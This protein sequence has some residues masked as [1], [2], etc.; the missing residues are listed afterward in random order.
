VQQIAFD[1]TGN[2][3]NDLITPDQ[4]VFCLASVRA[5]EHEIAQATGLLSPV[6]AREWKFCKMRRNPKQLL[7]LSKLLEMDWV[8]PA[9]VK[10]FVI[11]KRYMAMTKLVDLI[12][13]PSARSFGVNLYEKGA[14]RGLANLLTLT[15]PVYLGNTRADRFTNLFVRLVRRRD[16][17]TLRQFHREAVSALTY[18]EHRFP[19]TVGDFFAPIIMACEQPETWMPHLSSNELDPVIPAYHTLS[20]AW[21]KTLSET[22]IIL[23]DESKALAQERDLLLRFADEGLREHTVGP[24]TRNLT[25][26][27]KVAD[28]VTTTSHSSRSVQIADLFAGIAGYAFTPMANQT[29]A[30]GVAQDFLSR[31]AEKVWMDGII[32]SRDVTPE[33]LGMEDYVGVDP[34]DYGARILAEDP[35]TRK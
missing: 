24:P 17:D 7:L 31:L 2:T 28:I 19:E 4:P 9:N 30:E 33:Q 5:N 16:A 32:P 27:L 23:A 21:G 12:H 35:N 34:A 8:T 29:S 26:P 11:F 3:G 13:E 20:D 18:L 25:Y 15:L 1:E 14:A 10:I 6:K 22:F